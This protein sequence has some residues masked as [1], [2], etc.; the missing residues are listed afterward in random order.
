MQL[1]VTEPR[2]KF[3]FV[4]ET[5]SSLEFKCDGSNPVFY[6]AFFPQNKTFWDCMKKKYT[7]WKLATLEKDFL[8]LGLW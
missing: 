6:L 8:K 3:D 4:F 1:I 2:T 7:R 5:R